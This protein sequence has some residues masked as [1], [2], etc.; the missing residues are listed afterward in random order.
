M[1]ENTKKGSVTKDWYYVLG[2]RTNAT[3]TEIQNA[4]ND[5]YEKFGPHVSSSDADP[6]VQIRT[7]KDI[8]AAY[9]TLM[10]PTKRKEYDKVSAQYR[11]ATD[12][13]ALWGKITQQHS[14]Q[15]AV[16]KEQQQQ[17]H[18]N[19][20]SLAGTAAAHAGD[21]AKI[22]ALALEME[23]DVTLKEAVKGTRKQITITDPTPCEDCANLKPVN[24]MQCSSCRGLGYY[25]VDR[26]I[27]LDLPAGMYDGMEI[28]RQEQGRYDLRAGRYGDLVIKIKLRQHP[29]LTVQGRDILCS[30]PVTLY[31]AMLG[32]EIEIPTATGKGVIK[33]QPLTQPG[34]VYRLKGLGLAGSD[35]LVTISVVIPQTL[36]GEEVAHYRKLKE[37]S[38]DPNP[39]DALFQKMGTMT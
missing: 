32:S 14:Q 17:S 18:Q 8:C 10:D 2:I 12:V 4:Y 23:I 29:C 25:N 13:R 35:M 1:E 19:V 27:E 11:Q 30:V 34:R 6:D 28:R 21:S 36:S 3:T 31:E 37:L 26:A 9:E 20:P 16:A 38:K 15:A 22:Q 24:R 7:Y 39:R 33:I 5:L